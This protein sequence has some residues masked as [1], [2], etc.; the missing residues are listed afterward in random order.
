MNIQVNTDRHVEG[1]QR[2]ENYVNETLRKS[3][4]RFG[5][6]ITRIEAHISD[7]N[8]PRGGVDDMQC[9]LEARLQG[10][11]PI[12]VTNRDANIEQSLAG[13]I[14][15]LRSALDSALGKLRDKD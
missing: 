8:G 7:Q 10:M 1:H 13:A 6:R 5:E 4:D 2:L 12:T 3:L 9:R 15:K 14:D 11:Q